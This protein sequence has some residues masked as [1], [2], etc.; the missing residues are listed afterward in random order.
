LL[1][2]TSRSLPMHRSSLGERRALGRARIDADAE[3]G[4]S[5]AEILVTIVIVGITFTAILTAMVVSVTVSSQHRKEA[6]ADAVAR[7]A[8]EWVKDSVRTPY[9]NCPATYSVSGL[10]VPSGYSVSISVE[11]WKGFV[12]DPLTGGSYPI[13]AK[14]QTS[15]PSPDSGLQRITIAASTSNGV[16][17]TVQ[18]LKRTVS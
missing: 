9:A 6:T 10:T 15:C 12:G 5:L 7:S 11:Y 18:I 8:A 1:P 2:R 17:E 16:T 13:S 3:S 4:F 14:F